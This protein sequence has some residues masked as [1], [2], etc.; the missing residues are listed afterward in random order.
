MDMNNTFVGTK[1]MYVCTLF[2]WSR[3][4]IRKTIPKL[5]FQ[6]SEITRLPYAYV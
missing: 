6:F 4:L 5:P 1:V 2:R 3:R